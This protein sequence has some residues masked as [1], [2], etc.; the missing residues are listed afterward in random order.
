[1]LMRKLIEAQINTQQY[2]RRPYGVG[3]LVIGYDVC[4]NM[5]RKR[6]IYIYIYIYGTK[7]ELLD[8]KLDLICLNALLRVPPSSTMPCQLVHAH[9]LQK[10]TSRNI[11]NLLQMV[12]YC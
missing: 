12:R 7:M 10:H 2:G 3:L 11:M 1:M 6:D 5:S 8:R 4:N 9:N